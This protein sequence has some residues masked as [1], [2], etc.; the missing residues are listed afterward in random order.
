MDFGGSELTRP[1][2]SAPYF[3][4]LEPKLAA[5]SVTHPNFRLN[6]LGNSRP[7]FEQGN[8]K[9]D[10][11]GFAAS[12]L[13]FTVLEYNREYYTNLIYNMTFSIF[14]LSVSLNLE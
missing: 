4:K 2:K 13:I 8:K 9:Q 11:C 5:T 10:I 6:I 14:L 3:W 12:I 7:G 1:L